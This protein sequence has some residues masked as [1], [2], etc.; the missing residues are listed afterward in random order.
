MS[1]SSENVQSKSG[2]NR[3]VTIPLFVV[4]FILIVVGIT[5]LAIEWAAVD[6]LKKRGATDAALEDVELNPFTGEFSLSQLSVSQRDGQ[7]FVVARLYLKVDYL[8]LFE[9]RIEVR[10]IQLSGVDLDLIIDADDRLT[11][12]GLLL[13]QG[14]AEPASAAAEST[15]N[16]PA[17]HFGL[18]QLMVDDI[19]L[20]TY[21]PKYQG[22]IQI[23]RLQ[24]EQ[25][26]SWLQHQQTSV[27]LDMLVDG[28]KVAITS[29]VTPFKSDPEWRGDVVI[30]AINFE[31]Y[32]E[33]IKLA[34]ID[35]LTGQLSANLNID[36]KWQANEQLLLSFDGDLN[37]SKLQLK[38]RYVRLQQSSLVWR[39]KGAVHYPPLPEEPL[40]EL[41]SKL[42]LA[43]LSL[44]LPEQK[45]AFEQKYL[46]WDGRLHYQE[47]K[48]AVADGLR[49]EG[50]LLVESL[51]V[52]DQQAELKLASLQKANLSGLVIDGLEEI[53][54]EK[55]S[56]KQL[57]GLGNRQQSDEKA[58]QQL[59][60]ADD[61]TVDGI[62]LQ[63]L[64][65]LSLNQVAL[66]GM[67]VVLIR[68]KKGEIKWLPAP[69][70][71]ESADVEVKQQVETKLQKEPKFVLK[72]DKFS[73]EDSSIQF[74]DESVEPAYEITLTPFQLLV[75]QLDMAQ[76]DQTTKL[77]VNAKI[78]KYSSLD[79]N[80][81]LNPFQQPLSTALE[82]HL[83]GIDLTSLSPYMVGTIGYDF[84]RGRL[85]SES[86]INIDH[87]K[88]SISNELQIAKLTIIE[89]DPETA[90]NFSKT[91]VMPLDAALGILRDSDDNIAFNLP[92]TGDI[93]APEFSLNGVVNLALTNA[94][95]SAA[96]SYVTNALQPLGTVIMVYDLL[97]K[98]TQVRF[99][100]LEYSPGSSE[101]EGD[102]S[103][104]ADK[105]ATLL[106]DRQALKLTLCGVSNS[107]DQQVVK[108]GLIAESLARSVN[109]GKKI[110]QDDAAKKLDKKVVKAA[111]LEIADNRST[112]LK[113]YLM[114]KGVA[115][116]R[117]FT[118]RPMIDLE[119][120]AKARVEL[121]L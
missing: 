87:G 41:Q 71:T 2:N 96:M 112:G 98:V 12:G 88:L 19:R 78:D 50:V 115:E 18:D 68:N 14:E 64:N 118:C 104:Y 59:F 4:L 36:G 34:G 102:G 37:L 82:A 67:K 53:Q 6:W 58:P 47:D 42:S 13:P 60:A 81:T 62:S 56:L 54:V 7:R 46:E 76:P 40:L 106:V 99:Q 84:R 69:I 5:P 90:A 65:H 74:Q 110:T 45:L 39:G 119:K 107:D 35:E 85:D 86:T 3:F 94:L 111:L 116:T 79:I 10:S 92:V 28:A 120:G 38:H 23:N 77:M 33:L 1:N 103:K 66:H 27:E 32:A 49:L 20:R 61:L 57:T 44:E 31:N 21:L 22:N 9:R 91:L 43:G 11:L 15:T 72:L 70:D 29:K 25:V 63:Q 75:E 97:E 51:T 117:L 48:Q 8:P 83:K 93:S 26:A 55:L 52:I 17:W 109:K 24:V 89:A 73:I 105:V 30:E 16:S 114:E 100:P 101:L 80:G 95:K 121:A 113:S 108:A